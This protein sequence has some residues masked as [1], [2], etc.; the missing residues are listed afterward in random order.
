MHSR[1]LE[2]GR[3]TVYALNVTLRR[4]LTPGEGV[5]APGANRWRFKLLRVSACGLFVQQDQ[6]RVVTGTA[7][8]WRTRSATVN[9]DVTGN[10]ALRA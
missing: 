4:P 7:D 3:V 2:W 5:P 10:L 1:E 6:P 9:R 8:R